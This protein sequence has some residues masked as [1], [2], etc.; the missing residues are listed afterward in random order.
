MNAVRFA[1]LAD[2]MFEDIPVE[3]RAGV[4]GLTVEP[5]EERHPAL[6]GVWTMGECI[7]DDWSDGTGGLDD[8]RSRIV[9]YHGSFERLAADDPMFDWEAELW[10]T[11]VHELLHHR[12][13]T[14][15]E[16][17]LDVFDWAV[18]QNFR[19]HAGQPF[20]PAF[21]RAL[22][23]DDDGCVRIEG[24]TF[25]EVTL[26]P[27]DGIAGFDWR[28]STYELRV[29]PEVDVAFVRVKNLAGGRVWVVV[30]RRVSWWRRPFRAASPEPPLHIV[31]RALPR[32]DTNLMEM[33]SD[34]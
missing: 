5:G 16:S 1:R 29:P 6:P 28:G 33:M 24:E 30:R 4:D 25:I 8:T 32:L 21:H 11:I 2:R 9:L 10:E 34:G 7:T 22:A 15:S 26:R 27:E 19:R 13:A 14:A 12:E 3:F 20:D 18:D 23:A 31:R 17:G